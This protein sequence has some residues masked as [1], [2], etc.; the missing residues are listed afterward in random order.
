MQAT[1]LE[2]PNLRHC[3]QTTI[4]ALI[5]EALSALE[6]TETRDYIRAHTIARACEGDMT[7]A[8]A[9]LGYWTER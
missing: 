8:Y 7:A 2:R 1:K 9:L 3:R 4:A 5:S 6:V